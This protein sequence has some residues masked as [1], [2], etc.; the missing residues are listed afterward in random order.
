MIYM[1]TGEIEKKENEV[2]VV[3]EW[4]TCG[5][6]WSKFVGRKIWMEK[7]SGKKTKKNDLKKDAVLQGVDEWMDSL[8][9]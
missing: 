8:P 4:M 5:S 9:S 3:I 1:W 6:E 2:M 7:K